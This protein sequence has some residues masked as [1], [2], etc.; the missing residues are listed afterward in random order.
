MSDTN[1]DQ[2][3]PTVTKDTEQSATT[4]SSNVTDD[5]S[6]SEQSTDSGAAQEQLQQTGPGPKVLRSHFR[7]MPNQWEKNLHPKKDDK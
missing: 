7:G 2:N 4:A 6:K 3:Q 5:A 1:T